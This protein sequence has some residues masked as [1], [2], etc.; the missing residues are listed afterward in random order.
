M[1]LYILIL[2]LSGLTFVGCNQDKKVLPGTKPVGASLLSRIVDT[3]SKENT[4][5]DHIG[6][7]G[8]THRYDLYQRL[9]E[10]ATP[11]ELVKL[12]DHTNPAVRYYS[13]RALASRG[14]GRVFDIL[15]RHINDTMRVVSFSGCT[16]I[17]ETVR[18]NLIKIV[19][20]D[21]VEGNGYKLNESQNQIVDSLLKKYPDPVYKPV[22]E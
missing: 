15:L 9:N 14:D 4:I 21:K 2:L 8:S 6:I 11:P 22:S 19:T 7:A 16:G 12:T 18:H 13:F 17:T 5:G 1:N 10:F 20:T 3:L